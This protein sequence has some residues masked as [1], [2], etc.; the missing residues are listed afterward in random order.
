MNS[1]KFRHPELDDILSFKSIDSTNLEAKRRRSEFAGRN[2]LLIANEQTHGKGQHG[3]HWDSGA[4]LG[5]WLSLF[6]SRPGYLEHHLQLLSLYTGIIIQRVLATLI[7]NDIY[8]KWPN[9][10]MIGSRKCGGVLTE[11]QWVGDSAV[12]A[13]IGMGINLEHQ[14]ADFPPSIRKSAISLRQAGWHKP[15]PDLLLDQ[16]LDEFFGNIVLLDR[17][18]ELTQEWN[19]HAFRINDSVQWIINNRMVEGQFLGISET[20]EAQI[21]VE[22]KLTHFRSGEIRLVNH[23]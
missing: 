3:R 17:P 5:L 8:L 22:G 4:G 13:T 10:I 6:L 16:L 11:V 1:F 19:E 21:L 2:F 20:G 9:D 12:S 18:K 7:E 23:E 14:T 15:D